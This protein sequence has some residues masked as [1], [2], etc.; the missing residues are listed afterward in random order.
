[1]PF[2]RGGWGFG[3]RGWVPPWPF[4]GVGRG[5][6]PRCSYFLS[7]ADLPSYTGMPLYGTPISPQQEVEIL[8]NQANA[9]K[10]QLEQIE[11]RIAE[12]E[13]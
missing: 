2:G 8:K 4:I 10:A 9:L 6:L 13:K 12:L 11:G 5:G 3:F 7:G 1:M